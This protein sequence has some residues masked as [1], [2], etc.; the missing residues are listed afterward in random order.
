MLRVNSTIEPCKPYILLG[1]IEDIREHPVG[2]HALIGV[3]GALPG[4]AMETVDPYNSTLIL[5]QFSNAG[6]VGLWF[7]RIELRDQKHE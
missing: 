4:E 7:H 1:G 6:K 5:G 3:K 2:C